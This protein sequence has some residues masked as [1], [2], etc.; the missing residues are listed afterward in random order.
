MNSNSSAF[1]C[2]TESPQKKKGN[3]WK[4][5]LLLKKNPTNFH[6][7]EKEVSLGS[8]FLHVVH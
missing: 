2:I 4:K 7:V 1:L 3:I 5:S 6:Y 8:A